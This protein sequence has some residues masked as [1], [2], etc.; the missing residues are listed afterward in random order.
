MQVAERLKERMKIKIKFKMVR[1]PRVLNIVS[2]PNGCILFCGG[3][4]LFELTHLLGD[5]HV[6]VPLNLM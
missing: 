5:Q 4:V 3:Q 6:Y 1:C 2:I